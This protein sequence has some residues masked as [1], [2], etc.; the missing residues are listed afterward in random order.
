LS[1]VLAGILIA[2]PFFGQQPGDS[3]PEERL[4]LL[5]QPP[6]GVIPTG[7]PECASF[8][9]LQQ[10]LQLASSL[11][12]SGVSAVPAMEAALSAME[13][14][15]Q[16]SGN[17]YL[18]GLLFYAYASSRGRAAYPRLRAM[19]G[20]PRFRRIHF[21]LDSAI[22]FSLGLTSFVDSLRR[23]VGLFLCRLQEPKDALDDVIMAW[24]KGDRRSLE[25]S[26]GPTGISALESM[27][28]GKSWAEVR[29]G[30]RHGTSVRAAVGYRFDVSGLWAEPEGTLDFEIVRQRMVQDHSSPGDTVD[31]DAVFKDASD[32]DCGRLRVRFL[33]IHDPLN[34][35]RLKF[36][37]DNSD[38]RGLLGLIGGC[39]GKPK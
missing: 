7:Q 23:P 19:I 1:S 39:A 27:L 11:A 18:S 31:L 32:S 9:E 30:I 16:G 15:R 35:G 14:G 28:R 26:L 36:V 24:E 17:V 6:A 22:A 3:S 8:A 5:T 4:R 33:R 10:R 37:V 2:L 25:A 20:N 21:A 34:P 13:K 38:L 29:A 12:Q